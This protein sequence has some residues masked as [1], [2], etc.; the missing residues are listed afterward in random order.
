MGWVRL[1]EALRFDGKIMSATISKRGG[2]W[3][4]SV[5]VEIQKAVIPTKKTGKSV[6]VDLGIRYNMVT[7]LKRPENIYELSTE[8]DGIFQNTHAS[9]ANKLQADY[10]TWYIGVSI[11]LDANKRAQ[12]K[13]ENRRRRQGKLI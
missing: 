5:A 10:Y 2:K 13:E 3:F 8:N 1:K 11:K 7:G 9:L 12:K 6:G 4:V